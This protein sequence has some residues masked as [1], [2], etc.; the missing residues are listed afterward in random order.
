MRK[1]IG[2]YEVEGKEFKIVQDDSFF[3]LWVFNRAKQE[4]EVF[5]TLTGYELLQLWLKEVNYGIYEDVGYGI[6]EISF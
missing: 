6:E 1:E 3:E 5:D 4:W 2:L